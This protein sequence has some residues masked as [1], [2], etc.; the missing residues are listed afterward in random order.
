MALYVLAGILGR[1]VAALAYFNI[2]H[3]RRVRLA[4]LRLI[5]PRYG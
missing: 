3:R 2:G 5:K 1:V 4:N